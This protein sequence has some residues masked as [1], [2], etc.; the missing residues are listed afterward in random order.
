MSDSLLGFFGKLPG[1]IINA[2]SSDRNLMCIECRGIKLHIPV[3]YREMG[4]DNKTTL[5]HIGRGL[6]GLNDFAPALPT[7]FGNLF[8]CKDC[9]RIRSEG[10][11]LSDGINKKGRAIYLDE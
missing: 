6:M 5:N 4:G 7:V 2:A 10:G 1:K 8:A 3:S 11:V 9:K